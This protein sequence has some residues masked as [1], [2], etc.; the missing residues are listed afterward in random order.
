MHFFIQ[1]TQWNS[2]FYEPHSVDI[3]WA[4]VTLLQSFV[5]HSHSDNGSTFTSLECKKLVHKTFYL[6]P[7]CQVQLVL[8]SRRLVEEVSSQTQQVIKR[9]TR[10]KQLRMHA[11]W[12][13]DSINMSWNIGVMNIL[14]LMCRQRSIKYSVSVCSVCQ[15]CQAPLPMGF[16]SKNIGV[17]C[18]FFPQGIFLTQGPNLSLLCLLYWQVDSLLLSHLGS[19]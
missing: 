10:L 5:M 14:T 8:P 15:D 17:N 12:F 2:S 4:P 9:W 6:S 3:Y 11:M 1:V 18:Q 7:L 13:K 16:S 19:P